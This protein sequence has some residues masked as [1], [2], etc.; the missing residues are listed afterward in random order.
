MPSFFGK[1][2]PPKVEEHPANRTSSDLPQPNG[3]PEPSSEKESTMPDEQFRNIAGLDTDKEATSHSNSNTSANGDHSPEAVPNED[4]N[5]ES[6][7]RGDEEKEASN[8]E[9]TT[10]GESNAD[11]KEVD[12]I[13][14]PSGFKLGLITIALCLCV[15]CVALV[16]LLL[17]TQRHTC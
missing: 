8:A 9:N 14:Y 3:S 6:L 12:E 2:T 5:K 4:S 1:T 13:E 15:F 16:R 11:P 10:S 7:P 17:G